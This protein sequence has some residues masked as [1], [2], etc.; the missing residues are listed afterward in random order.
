MSDSFDELVAGYPRIVTRKLGSRLANVLNN[1]YGF[2]VSE[3]PEALATISTEAA[4]DALEVL[5]AAIEIASGLGE[6]DAT[7]RASHIESLRPRKD[8]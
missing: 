5:M 1:A 7:D 2:R 8:E 3:N 6:Q 4:Q